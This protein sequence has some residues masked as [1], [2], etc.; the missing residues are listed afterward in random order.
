MFNHTQKKK[1]LMLLTMNHLCLCL[2]FLVTKKN[3]NYSLKF[4]RDYLFLFSYDYL[5]T[6]GGRKSF[7]TQIFFPLNR[8]GKRVDKQFISPFNVTERD[9]QLKIDNSLL[10]Q[11]SGK[12]HVLNLSK[13]T[14]VK[15]MQDSKNNCPCNFWVRFSQMNMNICA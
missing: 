6:M 2:N 1:R 15:R 9:I 5:L 11:M 3:R 12:K 7:L 13:Y 14:S 8:K 10:E 4:E